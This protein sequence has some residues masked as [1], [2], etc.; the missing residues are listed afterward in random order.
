MR[1]FAIFA[2]VVPLLLP[3]PEPAHA[4]VTLRVTGGLNAATWVWPD[5]AERHHP[6]SWH[7]GALGVS[8]G[9]PIFG[10]WGIR[11]GADLTVKGWHEEEPC[12][13]PLLPDPPGTED[14]PDTEV[15][16]SGKWIP[17]FETTVLADRRIE[18]GDRFELYLL[19]GPFLGYQWDPLPRAKDFDFGVAG[20][21]QLDRRLSGG[22]GLSVGALYTHGLKDITHSVVDH[23]KGWYYTHS[24]TLSLRVGLSYR[25]GRGSG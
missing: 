24:R 12:A 21:A 4:Q 10:D 5:R 1:R 25:I 22:L 19:A 15:C 17:Y 16:E 23:W 18:L 6:L 14:P 2:A 8:A 7:G 3:P 13:V 20:G 9:L 11:V